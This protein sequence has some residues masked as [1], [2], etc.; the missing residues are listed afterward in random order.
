MSEEKQLSLEEQV[1]A[2]REISRTLTEKKDY[3]TANWMIERLPSDFNKEPLYMGLVIELSREVDTIDSN[4][5]PTMDR[6]GKQLF[7]YCKSQCPK[8]FQPQ[9]GEQ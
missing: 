1:E 4:E 9:E 5:N 3:I 6:L 8:Y 7:E 2:V